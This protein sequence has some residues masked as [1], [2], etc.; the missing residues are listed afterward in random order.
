MRRLVPLALL[1]VGCSTPA[2]SRDPAPSSSAA[3]SAPSSTAPAAKKDDPPPAKSA[4]P[5]ETA[6]APPAASSAP[7]VASSAAPP[8]EA[9][10]PKI[11]VANIGMH[12]GGGPDVNSDENKAPIRESVAPH[13]DAFRR[14]WG[15]IGDDKA[16]GDFGVD[17]LIPKEGGKLKKV[18]NV[19]TTFKSPGFKECVVKVFEDIE[20]KKPRTGLTKVSYSLRFGG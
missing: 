10:V 4:P 13:F 12:I 15:Q 17:L 9:P 11:K 8:S 20:F 19:R 7:A 6:S 18:D 2:A 14:C 5:A 3:W 16:K 1:L